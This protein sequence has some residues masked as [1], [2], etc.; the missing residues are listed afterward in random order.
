MTQE[1]KH[2]RKWKCNG[3]EEKCETTFPIKPTGCYYEDS[4]IPKD[5]DIWTEAS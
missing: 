5:A 4:D 1:I 2:E 3:C